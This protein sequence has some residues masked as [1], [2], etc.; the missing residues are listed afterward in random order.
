MNQAHINAE[1]IHEPI[2]IASIKERQRIMSAMSKKETMQY[3]NKSSDRRPINHLRDVSLS[4]K[5]K[6]YIHSAEKTV[7][8][9]KMIRSIER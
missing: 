5:I 9:F 4:L 6:D 1:M 8:Y 2:G 3:S 7:Y